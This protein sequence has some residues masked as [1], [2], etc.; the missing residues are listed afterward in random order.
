M[1]RIRISGHVLKMTLN[2]ADAYINAFTR[3]SNGVQADYLYY[4]PGS[5]AGSGEWAWSREADA[6]REERT[7]VGL[8]ET[9]EGL[10]RKVAALE[11][12]CYNFRK[13]LDLKTDKDLMKFLEDFGVE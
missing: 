9:V 8:M 4:P 3:A 11:E 5:S 12:L 13:I 1:S 7:V 2:T 10:K 6:R